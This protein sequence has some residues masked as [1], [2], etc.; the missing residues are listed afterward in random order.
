MRNVLVDH[1]VRRAPPSAA[2]ATCSQSKT[3]G[4]DAAAE[5]PLE[6]LIAREALGRLEQLAPAGPVVE[7]RFF[8][9][10]SLEETAEALPTSAPGQ[11][12]L[13]VRARLDAQRARHP[14]A[15][16]RPC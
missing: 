11:P 2:P 6:D 9:G 5:Q 8:G 16:R 3:A 14:A 12:R 4:A 13:D 10:W 1:A 7:C 15:R